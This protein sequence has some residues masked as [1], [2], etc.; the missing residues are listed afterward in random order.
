M[1]ILFNINSFS[2]LSN[3]G[4]KFKLN[5]GSG[6]A[7]AESCF[8]LSIT[9][10][11]LYKTGYLVQASFQINLG[12]KDIALLEKIKAFFGGVNF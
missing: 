8:T 9:K 11:K 2:S 3:R 1:Q 5:L 4:V 10:N 7:D 12:Q 6:F